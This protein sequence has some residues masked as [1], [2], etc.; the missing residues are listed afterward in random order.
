MFQ[1][2]SLCGERLNT[3]AIG[4]ELCEIR[5]GG[6][7]RREEKIKNKMKIKDSVTEVDQAVQAWHNMGG[8]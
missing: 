7:G 6:T 4:N 3:Y 1:Q 2:L 8:F 5:Q